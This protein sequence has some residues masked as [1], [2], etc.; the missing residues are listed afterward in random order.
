MLSQVERF[1][2]RICEDGDSI[3]T[4]HDSKML[5]EYIT[6]EYPK[7]DLFVLDIEMPEIDGLE[8]KKQISELYADTNVLFLTSHREMVEEA[9][10]KKVIGFLP[11]EDYEE[12][13]FRY[14]REI[15]TEIMQDDVIELTIG[16]ER[17]ILH[18]NR[19]VMIKAQHIYSLVTF[20]KY[21]N[22]DLKT[23]VTKEEIFRLSLSKWGEV[24]KDDTFFKV[25]RS[26]IIN[27][28]YVKRVT[29][30]IVLD[31]GE[32][33]AIPVRRVKQVKQAYNTYCMKNAKCM[34]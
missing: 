11:K 26:L 9:F 13:L 4:F 27:L 23:F 10:G 12:K 25:S 31:T 18:K 3:V 21:Y 22:K 20:Q 32:E 5:F 17:K 30:A 24:L 28:K 1:C 29:D 34:I 8:L 33:V 16:A 7:V 15:R 19:I 2:K 14:I 6:K